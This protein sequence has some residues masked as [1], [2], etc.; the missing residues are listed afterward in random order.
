MRYLDRTNC[1]RMSDRGES[2][3][4][5]S[6]GSLTRKATQ[7]AEENRL[8][9]LKTSQGGY[10]I[11]KACGLGAYNADLKTLKDA[12]EFLKNLD[13]HASERI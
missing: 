10:R 11:I 8:G 13:K 9:I 12:D 2:R 7:I 3:E 6:L 1:K 4:I 5:E